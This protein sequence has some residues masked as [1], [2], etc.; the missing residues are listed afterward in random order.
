MTAGPLSLYRPGDGPLHRAPV[1]TKLAGLL[2]VSVVVVVADAPLVSTLAAVVAL[3]GLRWIGLTVREIWRLIRVFVFFAAVIVVVQVALGRVDEGRDVAL[4]LLAV[5]TSAVLL[6]TT[7]RPSAITRWV[8]RVLLRLR[9]R[10]D[11]VFRVGVLVDVALRSIDHLGIVMQRV[12]E[13][14]RSRGLDRS[15]RAL[16]V[17]LVVSA[18]RFAHDLGEALDARG[19]S[20]PELSPS[21]T[22]D[23]SS[24]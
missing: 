5:A 10:P 16:A 22:P 15:V 4:R 6:T 14:R 21:E 13:A 23:A 1:W 17:P 20:E 9:V 19:I 8:E 11:R 7:T 2:L 24:Q 12:L 18:A 3:A